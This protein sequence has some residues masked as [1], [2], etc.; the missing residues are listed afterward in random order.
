MDDEQGYPYGLGNPH[1]APRMG[2]F[3]EF[4]SFW[5]RWKRSCVHT[6]AEVKA[7][8]RLYKF[9]HK[10]SQVQLPGFG[11]VPKR[12]E[13]YLRRIDGVVPRAFAV[14]PPHP[15]T[16]L[17]GHPNSKMVTTSRLTFRNKTRNPV[18]E[19]GIPPNHPF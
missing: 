19:I 13:R 18:P 12:A 14:R 2:V 11:G 1:I 3:P 8:A 17:N 7:M 16:F 15:C 9:R 10:L 4:F 5:K 6:E